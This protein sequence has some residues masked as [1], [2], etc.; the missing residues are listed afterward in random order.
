MELKPYQQ[1]VIK[2]LE[3][4]ISYFNEYNNPKI[5]FD[6]YWENKV[7]KYNPLTN[8]GMRPYK[9]NIPD[10]VHLAIKVPTAGGKTFIACNAIHTIHKY[11]NN[12]STKA[13]VWLV[14]WSNLLQQ[15]YNSL[16]NPS[17][18]YRE[19]LNSLFGHRVE[20]YLKEQLLQGANFNPSSVNEQLN[21][22][23]LNFSSLRIDK[24]KKEDRKIYQENGSL[25]SFRA[26][27]IDEDLL[28][29]G[30]DETA[31]INV[32]RSLNPIVI[33][34]E[35]HNAESNLSVEMLQNLNPSVVLDLTATPKENSNIISFVSALK[36][37]QE[38]MVKLPVIVYNH[39]KKEE[40]INSAL[41]LQRELELHALE[42]EKETGK[43]IRPIILFQAQS[44]IKGKNNTTFQK[45]KDQLVKI[46]IPEEQI[47]I[48]VSGIDELKGI[49]LMDRNCPV[50]Y[51]ITVNALKEGWD[52][53]N[54]Y[55]L[56]SLADK[57]SFVDVEQI[58]GRILRQPYVSKHKNPLL[59]MSYVL[60]ASSKF[61]ETLDS[62][63]KGL[64]DSGFSKDD[65]YA[66]ELPE[67]ELTND[68][69]LEEE[70]FKNVNDQQDE[71]NSDE[72]FDLEIINFQ[73]VD[74]NEFQP[75]LNE[76]QTPSLSTIH[77]TEKAKNEYD[78]FTKQV[79]YDLTDD[80]NEYFN[81]VMNK[82]PK[83]YFIEEDFKALVND[84]KIPQFFIKTDEN[85]LDGLIVFDE[86]DS[87]ETLVEKN[88]LLK[89]FN[90]LEQD[91]KID[92]SNSSA[93]VYSIDFDTSKKTTVVN[94]VT[95][96]AK[97]I[98]LNNILA[99]PKEKQVQDVSRIIVN[100]L[101][102]MTPISHQDLVK[103]ASRVFESLNTEQI[104]D[105]VNND[106][107]Y[108]QK[109]KNK[110][111]ELTGLYAKNKFLDLLNSNEI[112]TKS[113]FEFPKNIVLSN[114]SKSITIGKSLYEAEGSMNGFEQNM[115]MEIA[116]LSNV[117]FWHRNL[118]RGKGFYI[119]GSIS[120]HFPD[121]ILYTDKGN[122]IIIET[123][124]D[125]RGNDDSK[126]KNRLGRLW[127]Q[128]SGDNY[129]YF[130]V[131]QTI[132]VEDAYNASNITN[133]IS[134]L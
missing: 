9:D 74:I 30:T 28:I 131:F 109:I 81:Q 16:N 63:V 10:A 57:S 77:I 121:F 66:Q 39:H 25:E 69:I 86:L 128:K 47:K 130:M 5:A 38:N 58:L 11:L 127:A 76:N 34:D 50:K 72:N 49:N 27:V 80:S 85:E 94:K 20:V 111:N 51:I 96:K 90:L 45:I 46:G 84:I 22:F 104:T 42:E 83:K 112:F 56:A 29:D 18:P 4:F 105:L 8:T 2:D 62:I 70:L 21:I 126:E 32:I 19:K 55:I 65:Y 64:Q 119:N 40:V 7:G 113:H 26:S 54:A 53:P 37:K 48:K 1:D 117:V 15:T 108:I 79:E 36:L 123:K 12:S 78:E 88:Y 107:I 133:I 97:R 110:I 61:K 115:I 116:S 41:H 23:V 101:G 24:A 3:L 122:I 98:L 106:F 118:G 59:N 103:Y 132:N 100:K 68:E 129:K 99:K 52:C 44:N 125:D 6:S 17:H 13:V 35:S 102:D 87:T 31:L 82:E 95:L 73:P 14:P 75:D 91:S 89:G 124:G 120:N 71:I 67:Q 93:E 60:T 92:F 33:V 114:D 43:Y 134:R